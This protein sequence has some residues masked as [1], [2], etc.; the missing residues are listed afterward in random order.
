MA[1]L[2]MKYAA[3]PII[4]APIMTLASPIDAPGLLT[5]SGMTPGRQRRWLSRE[6][7]CGQRCRGSAS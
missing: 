3:V 7:G 1:A 6:R 5:L 4:P 2:P